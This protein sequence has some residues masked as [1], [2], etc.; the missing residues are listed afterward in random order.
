MS[1]TETSGV[2]TRGWMYFLF[3]RPTLAILLIVGLIGGGFVAYQGLVEESNPDLDIPQAIVT[4]KWAGADPETM[5]NQVTVALEK[6]LKG[7]DGLKRLQSSSFD[8]YCM[9]AVEFE[10]GVDLG[11][12][13]AD[14]RAKVTEAEA[15]FPEDVDKPTIGEVS[16]VDRPV[17]SV[18]LVGEID[19]ALRAKTARDL[20]RRLER[21]RG[22]NEVSLSGYREE[23]VRVRVLLSRL[24]EL[25]LPPTLL[26]Q[27]LEE[28]SIDQPWDRY[29]SP[30]GGAVVVLYG[31]F[32]TL[33]DL[34]SL[35][36]TRIEERVVTLGE[37]AEVERGLER[38]FSRAEL[39]WAGAPFAPV[40]DVSVTRTPGSDAI[41]VVER[42]RAELEAASQDATWPAG[43]SYEITADGSVDIIEELDSVFNNAWQATVAV[44][45]V[46]LIALSWR[47]A[48]IAGLAI[49]VTFGGALFF[50][51]LF[52][53]TLNNM[54]IIG[55]ILALGLL[56]DVFIL[57]MEGMH[58]GI[59]E[60]HEPF[61]Q[62][63]LS[64]VKTYA[65][66]AFAGQLTTILAL[67][68]LMAIGGI[69]GEFIRLIPIAAIICLLLSFF[70]S[71]LVCIPMSQFLLRRKADE[72][73]SR[74]DQI[75]ARASNW[76]EDKL[77]RLIVPTK[78]RAALVVLGCLAVLVSAFGVA[79]SLP[80][81]LFPPDDGRDM[82]ITIELAPD[83]V[84]EESQRCADAVGEVLRENPLFE[85][86][87]KYVGRRSPMALTGIYERILPIEDRYFVGF[88]VRFTP[89][90]ERD[91]LAFEYVDEIRKEIETQSTAC[92]GAK[93]LMRPATG[94]AT[95]DDPVSIEVSGD[96]MDQLRA[97]TEEVRET[98][99][100]TPGAVDVRDNLGPA[101]LTIRVLPSREALDFHGLSARDLGRQIRS[102]M[103]E[104]PVL[105][106]PVG[107]AEEDIDVVLGVTWPS[108][109]G[110][111]GGP[112]NRWEIEVL[113][114][115]TQ[116][117][118]QLPINA[119][120]NPTPVQAP[121]AI[122]HIAGRRTVAI[123]SRV[124]GATASEVLARVKPK[125]DELQASW[126]AGTSYRFAGE[127]DSTA[128][129]F[130]DA[131]KMLVV[132]LF[133]VFAVL[134]LQFD[135]FAQPLIMMVT[136]P[137]GLIGTLYFFA[138][139]GLP[140]SFPMIIG[141]ISLV[142]IVVND[143][144]VM[145]STMNELRDAGASVQEAAAKG[146]AKRLRPILSTTFTTLAGMI[147]LALS[148]PLW[149][150]LASAIIWGLIAAS[151]FAML[152][153]PALYLLLTRERT[154]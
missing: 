143:A 26:A 13:M 74:I 17:I 139:V 100:A 18:A 11:E 90:E 12:A 9:V 46:L 121:I 69:S 34:R 27:R 28:A 71:L 120:A 5:E 153:T 148:A 108:R 92:P 16:I 6:Q 141:V 39:S 50:V 137:M 96:N 109:Q 37:L 77:A 138:A 102:Q 149:F 107:G 140:I 144:I 124:S 151:V 66:P 147:P 21:I 119:V 122:T 133:L 103:A 82:G 86:V 40:I 57:M 45:L 32:R 24:A 113:Q 87:T 146:A 132:A 25:G 19:D 136:V 29:E 8:S 54:V 31:R 15:D 88:S 10:V 51:W 60:K 104:D 38:E 75:S 116:S 127:A 101:R 48:L 118:E 135:S 14:L 67:A 70:I 130:G 72:G 30:E 36:I 99:A 59:Y 114:V 53:Y 94:G 49:P 73:P 152:T 4:A 3:V 117:G 65:A 52:G 84:L 35:P 47:E 33:D 79:G 43:M 134:A 23:V 131:G 44:F 78:R 85:S 62:A 2:S 81:E 22:V 154:T 91:K 41:E 1:E 112:T 63:A 68:P 89:L 98:L 142:G 105:Q 56:V 7:L 55:M 97:I 110:Q 115:T 20:Q 106:Y 145:I 93:L 42:V 123:S 125:L 129:T 111:P 64:T 76:L 83:T 126:P 128:E 80:T 61:A 150:P 95:A 58:E